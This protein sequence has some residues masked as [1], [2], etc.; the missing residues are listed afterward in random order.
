MVMAEKAHES[1]WGLMAK[2]MGQACKDPRAMSNLGAAQWRDMSRSLWGAW[3]WGPAAV[4][5]VG[6]SQALSACSSTGLRRGARL[7]SPSSVKPGA[8]LVVML[9][10]CMQDAESFAK[11]TRMDQIAREQG[12]NVLYPDQES[13]ANPLQCWNWNAPENHTRLGGEPEA[14]AGLIKQAQEKCKSPAGLTRLAGISA[15]A[16]L[17][18]SMAQLYPELMGSVAVVAGPAPFSADTASQ[19]L[20]E[21]A[22]GPD[23]KADMGRR[24]AKSASEAGARAERPRTLPMLIVQ[25]WAD[26]TVNPKNADLQESG[27]L[28]LNGAL[29][30]GGVDGEERARPESCSMKGGSSRVWRDGV[31]QVLAVVVRPM[32]LGHA[33]SGGDPSEPF[34]QPGFDQSRLALDF[35]EAAESGDWSSFHAKDLSAR[36][37]GR[38][39]AK[40]EQGVGSALEAGVGLAPGRAHRA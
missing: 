33:W 4:G 11:L 29:S 27:A 36:L 24:M 18:A 3:S 10:G 23:P 6:E 15:G 16:A 20:R 8:P 7:F 26:D 17:A 25:G 1:D 34:S 14:L 40:M 9:H 12:F 37:F 30:H 31:G 5:E 32:A 19:A 21:M 38:R 2:L 28:M 35:F 13:S 22:E 39:Q